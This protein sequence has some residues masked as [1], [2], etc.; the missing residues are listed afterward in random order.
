MIQLEKSMKKKMPLDQIIYLPDYFIGDLSQLLQ[1]EGDLEILYWDFRKEVNITVKLQIEQLLNHI[2]KIVKNKEKRRNRY[3]LL[4]KYLFCYAESSGL[5]DI[6]KMELDQEKEFASFLK[7]K[8]GK[9]NINVREFIS[10]CRK[11]LF[12]ETKEI[13]WEAN[14]WYVEKLNIAPA[15]YSLS[16]TIESFSFLDIC[17]ED[18]RKMLQEYMKY[19]FTVT[20]LNLGT[21]RVKQ[22]YIKEF[23]KYLE[24]HRKAIITIDVHLIKKYFEILSIQRI[25][26]QSYNNKIREVVTFLQYLKVTDHIDHFTTPVFFYKK[27][28]YSQNHEI[29]DLDQ[30]LDLLMLHLSE[31]PEQ[32]RI[33]SLLLMYTGVDK[34][35]LFLLRNADFYYE[36]EN[37]WM[38]VPGTNR[39]V[40]IPDIVHLLILRYSEK[41]HIDIENLLF[42]NRDKKYTARS[43]EEAITRQCVKSGILNGEYVFKG[44]G[45]QKELCKAFYRNGI[46]IQAIREYMGYSTDET[47]KKYIGWV[48]E[49]VVRKSAEFFQQEE[50]SLGGKLLMAKYDKMNEANRLESEKK[51]QL[52]IA[53]IRRTASEGH[54]ISVSDLSRDTGLSKGFFYK[55]EQVRNI[56]NE[57]K[58]KQDPGTLAQIKREV[59]DKSL[60]KQ[61]ELYQREI[62]RLLDENEN[63]KKENRK[64]ARVLNKLQ[65]V[66]LK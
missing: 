46:S 43:F 33:M 19:L 41:K 20:N 25:S 47:V 34:G 6:L 9:S 35:K 58:E 66:S 39:S 36:N 23:L 16:S 50:N 31:F 13:N 8:T 48:D 52:A 11:T 65:K 44:N 3:L 45:Y 15:R 57:E 29:R 59:R 64:L 60:E 37:S 40:P 42:L 62:R 54:A 56:L 53:E 21:I 5:Q 28:S 22:T 7:T 14:I 61:I 17:L 12:L 1:K 30:K 26:S 27:K 51:I 63:L 4:L 38:K 55:N 24:E 49:E 18:N 2:V 32:V 10:F